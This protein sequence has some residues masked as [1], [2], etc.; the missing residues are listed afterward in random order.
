MTKTHS[1]ESG[2][3]A[4]LTVIDWTHVLAGPFVGYQM[5]LLGANVIRVERA[6]SDDMIRA[7]A[8]DQTLARVGLGETFITQGSGKRSL[9]LDMRDARAQRALESLIARADVLLENFRPGKLARLGFDPVKLIERYPKLVVC[10]ITGFGQASDKRAYDHVVQAA[11]GLME[12]NAGPDGRP[13]RIGFPL[14]DYAV[15]Q[16]AA[17]AVLAALVRRGLKP[18]RTRGEWVQVSM[19]GAALTLMAPA[20]AT[21]LISGVEQPRSTA[22]AFS[23]NPLS[24]TFAASDGYLAIVCNANNQSDALLQALAVSGA[25]VEEAQTLAR[26]AHAGNIEGTQRILTAVLVRRSVAAW[27]EVLEAVGVPVAAVASPIE[28]ARSVSADWPIVT[29]DVAGELRQT[30]VPGIGFQS[31]EVLT[32]SLKPPA[33]R[34]QHT[35]EIL[36]EAGLDQTTIEAMLTEGVAFSSDRLARP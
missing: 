13:Q 3:L 18:Q 22:T 32:T 35:I 17:L 9:A 31:T 5:A 24:G 16:Q 26:F 28:A 36:A 2:P 20:Y 27:V 6:D 34:G 19:M 21:P 25:S 23:G 4:G 30:K 33:R 14:V 8:A 15:G 11:S 12:A 29:I 7:K 10:S 1:S